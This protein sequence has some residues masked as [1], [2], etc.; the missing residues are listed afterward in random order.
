MVTV[1]I[2]SVDM[3]GIITTFMTNTMTYATEH[4]G[5]DLSEETIEAEVTRIL[6]EAILAS[7]G[8]AVSYTHLDVY[9]R[10]AGAD[11]LVIET[12][13][14]LQETRAALIAA[15]EECDLPVMVTM[16]FEEN[17]RTLYGTDPATA[18]VVLQELGADAVGVNC[19]T[20]PDKMVPIMKEMK[21]YAKVPMIAKPNAGLPKME[22]N[23]TVYD[24]GVEEFIYYGR[25]LI[26]A[27]A[28][29][30]GGCCGTTPEFIEALSYITKG[31][32]PT[33]IKNPKKRILTSERTIQQID[34]DGNFLIVGE[35]INPTGKKKLQ[36]E[37]REGDLEG[38]VEFAREQKEDGAKILDINVGMNGINEKETML[39]AI[40][41]IGL[42]V[43]LPLCI[44]SSYPDVIEAAL[45]RYP[46]RA[47]INSVSLE[48]GKADILL[49]IARKYGAM[50][51]LLPLSQSGLP[52]NMEEKKNIIHTVSNKALE[53]GL[54]KED[55]V[56]RCV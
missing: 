29:V 28:G 56:V 43:S 26:E 21:K 55:I 35:R 11:L 3:P 34:L 33:E 37:L 27:G 20:G 41:E 39:N 2:T 22:N 13:M 44:D 31:M 53:Y 16:T 40:D 19:S 32:A 30:I 7:E 17:G 14:S 38:V 15:K 23:Q 49:P 51:I 47:L 52:K 6:N 24:M 12:M 4:I 25:Q 48:K 36:E 5:E 18:I 9:K 10:Q 42:S 45:R 46:G 8:S 50:F 54:E 1:E